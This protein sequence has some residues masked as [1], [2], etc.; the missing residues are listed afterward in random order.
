MSDLPEHLL[1]V[2]A[3]WG[4]WTLVAYFL[5]FP[6]WVWLAGAI[7]LGV[8]GQVLLDAD[9]WF[10]GIGIGGAALLLM[11]LSNL[12]LVVT[13]WVRVAVLRNRQR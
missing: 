12:L 9:E 3:V 13:D 2:F 11:Q 6:E 7:A 5:T 4:V 1:L 8:V 10:L